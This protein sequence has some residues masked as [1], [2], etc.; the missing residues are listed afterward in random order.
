MQGFLQVVVPPFDPLAQPVLVIEYS[1]Q[2]HGARVDISM[3][4]EARPG[5]AQPPHFAQLGL[6]GPLESCARLKLPN[7]DGNRAEVCYDLSALA[8]PAAGLAT[9]RPVREHRVFKLTF[10]DPKGDFKIYQVRAVPASPDALPVQCPAYQEG[11]LLPSLLFRG[12]WNY[13]R[14]ADGA[15]EL[16]ASSEGFIWARIP[17]TDLKER[18]GLVIV[19]EILDQDGRPL[20]GKTCTLGLELKGCP[21]QLT[22]EDVLANLEEAM[23]DGP[24]AGYRKALLIM[25]K[26]ESVKEAAERFRR[27]GKIRSFQEE[28]PLLGEDSDSPLSAKKLDRQ[29]FTLAPFYAAQES[30]KAIE[31]LL[32]P[33]DS[34][35]PM[36]RKKVFVTIPCNGAEQIID[37]SKLRTKGSLNIDLHEARILALSDVQVKNVNSKA[38]LTIRRIGFK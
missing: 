35:I 17:P 13:Q 10:A 32:L 3:Q 2:G 30:G 33:A 9:D 19:A 27:T 36:S 26:L 8:L 34:G 31:A 25:K 37:L 16:A 11:N 28:F 12:T 15:I 38:R 14:H 29:A 23:A 7:T 21:L 24:Q 1:A 20:A 4:A 5:L 22:E 6:E 18:N